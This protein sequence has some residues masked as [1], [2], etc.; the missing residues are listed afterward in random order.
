MTRW[1]LFA[2]L[3]GLLTLALVGSTSSAIADPPAEPIQVGMAKTFFV[4]IPKILVDIAVAPFPELM[5]TTTG[6]EGQLNTKF[7]AF[8]LAQK[9]ND[10]NLQLG[11]FHGHEFAWVQKKYPQLK[12]LLVAVNKYNEVRVFTVVHKDS[13]AQKIADLRGKKLDLPFATKQHCR[14]YME[15]HCQDNDCNKPAAF[16]ST[17]AQSASAIDSMDEVCRGKAEATIVDTIGLEFYKDVKG[18]CFEKNLRIL[19]QSEPFPSAVI[20]CKQGVLPEA[21]INQ[22]RDGLISA[23]KTAEGKDM[24]SMWKIKAF[25]PIPDSYAESLSQVLKAYPLPQ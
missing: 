8:E 20:V 18:P 4:D 2:S 22:F 21:T 7:D 15:K 10:G 13:P 3:P 11:V 5:K 12:P 19:Q 1:K 24:M 16:F 23:H 17:I 25:E 14:V 9:L 6:L